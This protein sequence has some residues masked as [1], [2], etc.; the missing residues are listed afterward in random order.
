MTTAITLSWITYNYT[1]TVDS[2]FINGNGKANLIEGGAG[3]DIIKGKPIK[4]LSPA[5]PVTTYSAG[6]SYVLSGAVIR[7]YCAAALA[8]TRFWGAM[9][10]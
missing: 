1:D 10:A 7:T 3:N 2:N 6:Q 5:A 4:T 8:M 9:T